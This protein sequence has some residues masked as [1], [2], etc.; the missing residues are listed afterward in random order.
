MSVC[1]EGIGGIGGVVLEFVVAPSSVA[2]F[3]LEVRRYGAGWGEIGFPVGGIGGGIGLWFGA[4]G[5]LR[6][7]VC[8]LE[9]AE[10]VVELAHE[11]S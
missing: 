7:G 8:V 5:D 10:L 2:D 6:R 3:V 11:L 9:G 1:V 4:E